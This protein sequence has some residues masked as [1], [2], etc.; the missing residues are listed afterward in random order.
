VEQLRELSPDDLT[1]A[2]TDAETGPDVAGLQPAPGEEGDHMVDRMAGPE[3][4]A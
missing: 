3:V 1:D 2:V 4:T